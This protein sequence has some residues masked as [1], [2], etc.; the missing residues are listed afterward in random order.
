M[1]CKNK[2]KNYPA[3]ISGGLRNSEGKRKEFGKL[4]C[5]HLGKFLVG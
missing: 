1:Q 5:N 2:E 3:N 4:A